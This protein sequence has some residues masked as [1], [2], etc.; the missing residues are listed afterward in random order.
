MKSVVHRPGFPQPVSYSAHAQDKGILSAHVQ[1][2]LP[3]YLTAITS[4]LESVRLRSIRLK[5]CPGDVALECSREQRKEG[6]EVGSMWI[7]PSDAQPLP[8]AM[9][10]VLFFCRRKGEWRCGSSGQRRGLTGGGV[11]NRTRENTRRCR[12]GNVTKGMDVQSFDR[13]PYPQ[14]KSRKQQVIGA[15]RLETDNGWPQTG[16]DRF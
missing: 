2:S 3:G 1:W 6:K 14:R 13:D 5:A 11:S 8:R 10:T 4:A 9:K 16:G 15:A 12:V 7:H